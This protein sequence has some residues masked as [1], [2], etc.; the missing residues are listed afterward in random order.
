MLLLA[1]AIETVVELELR[2][3]LKIALRPLR[4]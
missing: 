1:D 2:L 3:I 4:H